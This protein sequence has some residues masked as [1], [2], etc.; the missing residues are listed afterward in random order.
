MRRLG[1]R[2]VFAILTLLAIP[3]DSW[4]A[5]KPNIVLVTMDA[6]RTDRMGF[7][8]AHAGLTPNLDGIAHDSIVFT[9]AYSQSPLTIASH[10]T[11]LTGTYPQTHRASEFSVPLPAALP[12]VPELLHQAGYKT[13]AFVGSIDLDPHAGSVQGYDRGFDV[14]DA[15]FHRPQLGAS[16]YQSIAR[17]DED[18]VARAI[19]WIFATK[20]RPFFVWINLHDSD[21]T[22][23]AYDQSVATADG[24]M[25]KL[26]TS[27]RE[28]SINDDTIVLVASAFGQSLGRH[29]E[30]AHGMFLY[31]ETIHVPLLLKLPT[32]QSAAKQ[33]K[34][35]A[36]LID[37]APT[38]LEQAGIPVPSQMQG[39]SLARIAQSSSQAEQP[40]YSRSDFPS[41]NFGCSAIE[42]WRAGKYLYV[43]APRPELYDLSTDPGATH[44]LAQS[45]KATLETLAS[46]LQSFDAR[47]GNDSSKSSGAGLTS[48]EMQKLSSLGYV[49]LQQSGS[50]VNAASVGSDPKDAIS[51]A[52]HIIA[53]VH[54]LEDGKPEK[55]IPLLKQVL[56][57]QP[58][59]Y[60]AEY[61]MGEALFQQQHYRDAIP[62]LHKAIELQPD[63]AWAHYIMGFTLMK[64]GDYKTATV[65]LEIAAGRL[66][67][68][69]T[70]HLALTEAK[71]NAK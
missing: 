22:A 51:A 57:S 25:G 40:G 19:Q 17:H 15:G 35:R 3:V 32:K 49:G 16:R 18:V 60:Q 56:A 11:I 27:L 43:R 2:L 28:H 66:P 67:G 47:L 12:Y 1:A 48:S 63:S 9:Q 58:N 6:V 59:A 21:T 5:A 41:Q 69:A 44:N 50:G 20:Q 23:A 13:A 4:C 39:Q 29:G 53:A 34:N 65:H 24:A 45:S 62:Y 52:N 64:T 10:A 36:R 33:V 14:Y 37:I 31:D 7:L 55:A 42:S 26:L 70:A 71:T 61:A 8:G 30:D 54:D 38:L 68:F 46:Q